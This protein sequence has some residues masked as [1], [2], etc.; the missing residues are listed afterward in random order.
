MRSPCT[1]RDRVRDLVRGGAELVEVLPADEY[2][3]AHLPGALTVPV[4]TRDGRLL[5]LALIEDLDAA[6]RGPSH[7]TGVQSRLLASR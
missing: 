5:G 3:D 4:T 6:H 1:D 7:R 2:D